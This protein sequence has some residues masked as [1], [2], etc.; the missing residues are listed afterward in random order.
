MIKSGSNN[1]TNQNKGN[2]DHLPY[3]NFINSVP[4][5]FECEMLIISCITL[6]HSDSGVKRFW[7][8]ILLNC[9]QSS[10][11]STMET[12]IVTRGLRALTVT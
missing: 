5:E 9:Q 2:G 7:V 3:K 10:V 12:I 4:N 6:L 11:E 8:Q 1:I